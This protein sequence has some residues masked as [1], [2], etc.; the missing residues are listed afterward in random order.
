MAAYITGEAISIIEA[1]LSFAAEEKINRS[2]VSGGG[3]NAEIG[4]RNAKV[5]SRAGKEGASLSRIAILGERIGGF[6]V[7]A[8]VGAKKI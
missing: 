2:E 8:I 5:S 3:E 1:A 6:G 4:R 7:A